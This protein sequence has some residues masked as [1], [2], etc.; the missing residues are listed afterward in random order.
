MAGV[1]AQAGWVVWSVAVS[2]VLLGHSIWEY[3]VHLTGRVPYT[4]AEVGVGVIQEGDFA[5]TDEGIPV[6][7]LP[8]VLDPSSGWTSAERE[9]SGTPCGLLQ[10]CA[11]RYPLWCSAA[12][13]GS[14]SGCE[15]G[16][17]LEGAAGVEVGAGGELVLER[18]RG[19]VLEVGRE[20]L[21]A[22]EEV[23]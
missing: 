14:A 4:H 9:A 15:A 13:E 12:W 17:V 10:V 8:W 2:G 1:R 3:R 7:G 5:P 6:E 11:R 19:V 20:G 16:G 22:R 18:S 23:R 21:V